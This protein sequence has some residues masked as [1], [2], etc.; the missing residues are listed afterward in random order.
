MSFGTIAPHAATEYREIGRAYSV[1]YI[2]TTVQGQPAILQPIDHVGDKLLGR[3]RYTYALTFN[4]DA[5]A[6][7]EQLRFEFIKD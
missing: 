6:P 3:G 4:A 2:E 1:A 7:H 5:R